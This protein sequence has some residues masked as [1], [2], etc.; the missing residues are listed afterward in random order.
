MSVQRLTSSQR[1]IAIQLLAKLLAAAT[2][3]VM[4]R[5]AEKAAVGMY[6]SALIAAAGGAIVL[7]AGS[8]KSAVRIVSG[9]G[10]R[11]ALGRALGARLLVLRGVL[12]VSFAA[13]AAIAGV[14][15]EAIVVATAAMLAL[16]S[17]E[18]G[19]LLGE[20][21]GGVAAL[22]NLA[23]NA[24]ALVATIALVTAL[25]LHTTA[26]GLMTMYLLGAV[27]AQAVY[28]GSNAARGRLV[29]SIALVR[30]PGGG[31]H[32]PEDRRTERR[33]SIIAFV[34]MLLFFAYFRSDLIILS[35]VATAQA[36]ALYAVAYRVFE[37]AVTVPS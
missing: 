7:D 20:G 25:R 27:V 1:Y 15:M 21:R 4:A 23:F 12:V 10:A 22:G 35:A 8:S 30:G 31:F 17:I 37:T 5:G 29:N 26:E 16:N 6:I 18:E 32:T 14:R 24:V 36:V 19:A 3:V 9:G 11:S 34:L 2:L 13:A 28:L 33:Y